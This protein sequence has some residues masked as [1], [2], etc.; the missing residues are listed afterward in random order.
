MN[1]SRNTTC[2]ALPTGGAPRGVAGGGGGA[3]EDAA[4]ASD[5]AH[6]RRHDVDESL[7]VASLLLRTAH[8]RVQAAREV[9]EHLWERQRGDA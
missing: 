5:A 3:L 7:V 1:A 8:L 2:D 9:R 4:L 6:G